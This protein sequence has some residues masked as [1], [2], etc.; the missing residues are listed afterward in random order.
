MNTWPSW[1]HER[2]AFVFALECVISLSVVTPPS[3]PGPYRLRSFL[4]SAQARVLAIFSALSQARRA[5]ATA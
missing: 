4:K 5:V 2:V 1:L 3:H